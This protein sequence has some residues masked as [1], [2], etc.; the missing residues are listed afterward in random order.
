[1][2][3]I[4]G[5]VSQDILL[6]VNKIFKTFVIEDYFSFA[7]GVV[8]TGARWCTLSCEYLLEFAKN[9]ETALMIY[10][11]G[12][13][14]KQIHEKNLKSKISWHCPFKADISLPDI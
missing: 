13:S 5:T 4:I 14:R 9:V 12:A 3:N 1:M 8:D 6:Q 7:T 2:L 10:S 11:A